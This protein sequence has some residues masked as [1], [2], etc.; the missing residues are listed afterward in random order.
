MKITVREIKRVIAEEFAKGDDPDL[1]DLEFDTVKQDDLDE[2]TPLK[3]VA[4]T[5]SG[6][7]RRGR[8]VRRPEDAIGDDEEMNLPAS[9]STAA[10]N[11]RASKSTAMQDAMQ[12]LGMAMKAMNSFNPRWH[13]W[14]C[15][16]EQGKEMSDITINLERG[17]K[18]LH[19]ELMSV[20]EAR[21]LTAEDIRRIVAEEVEKSGQ[22]DELGSFLGMFKIPG[23]GNRGRERAQAA[24]GRKAAPAAPVT[25]PAQDTRKVSPTIQKVRTMISDMSHLYDTFT[26][27]MRRKM[28][29]GA[30]G[31]EL[32]QR[33]ITLDDMLGKL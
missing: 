7:G 31:D 26:P 8:S 30:A 3:G 27:Q 29:L 13:R 32:V 22:L 2:A 15:R 20:S 10:A 1:L 14:V 4:S 21:I 24:R 17:L 11:R 25:A 19:R 5:P 12:A 9:A 16:T 23:L 33:L 18:T 28:C 6:R